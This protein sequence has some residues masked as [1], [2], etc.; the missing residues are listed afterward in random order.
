MA[1]NVIVYGNNGT[2]YNQLQILSDA[3]NQIYRLHMT[4]DVNHT[5]LITSSIDNY[6]RLYVNNGTQLNLLPTLPTDRSIAYSCW[7]SDDFNYLIYGDNYYINVYVPCTISYCLACSAPNQCN[8]CSG[9]YS[10]SINGTC[11]CATGQTF[12]I[13]T[14]QCVSCS[15]LN[16]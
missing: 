8:S 11:A 3:T 16:C 13:I 10:V 1:G 6:A 14:N 9:A 7:M 15:V 5:Y 12:S 4:N 2:G